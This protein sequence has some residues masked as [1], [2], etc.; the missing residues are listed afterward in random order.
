MTDQKCENV[1]VDG[2]FDIVHFG[3]VY[4]LREARKY[5]KSLTVGIHSDKEILRH[6][7]NYPVFNEE[8][9]YRLVSGLKFVDRVVENAP[10]HTTVASLDKYNCDFCVVEESASHDKR[11]EEVRRA[12]RSVVAKQPFEVS[13]KDIIERTL[14]MHSAMRNG[15]RLDLPWQEG[16]F[17]A[18]SETFKLFGSSS[19]PKEGDKIV[20]ACGSFDFFNVGHLAFLEQAK[21][22]GDYL[23]VGI[24]SDEEIIQ[25]EGYHPIMSLHERALCAFAY[26]PVD[27]ILLGAP[28]FVDDELLERFKIDIVARGVATSSF[29]QERFVVPKKR[30]ILRIIDSGSSVTTE[31]ILERIIE[32]RSPPDSMKNEGTSRLCNDVF[33]NEMDVTYKSQHPVEQMG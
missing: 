20:Y 33:Y 6:T 13:S 9:R 29:D 17:L 16:I 3:D 7:G 30:G 2:S 11:S 32:T 4:T 12:G 27:E 10:Y 23:I 22:L 14:R 8:E 25:G 24:Y 18:T 15:E 21:S 1:W 5:G 31:T 26:K 28:K 19:K